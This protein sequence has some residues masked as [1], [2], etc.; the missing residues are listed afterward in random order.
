M[1]ISRYTGEALPMKDSPISVFRE[2]R[3]LRLGEPRRTARSGLDWIA[4]AI[5][6][7][8]IG[9]IAMLA[10]KVIPLERTYR[11]GRVY[12]SRLSIMLVMAPIMVLGAAVW[13]GYTRWR[14]R[15]TVPFAFPVTIQL[16]RWWVFR[17]DDEMLALTDGADVIC[18]FCRPAPEPLAQVL[19]LVDPGKELETA[20]P[21]GDSLL[22]DLPDTPRASG[23][24]MQ[25]AHTPGYAMVFAATEARVDDI[26]GV[27]R[28]S[29]PRDMDLRPQKWRPLSG[30]NIVRRRGAR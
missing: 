17:R 27:L 2:V 22:F 15:G 20:D 8:A 5:A 28:K 14:D 19:D 7:V 30:E 3:R 16:P 6:I 9:G 26:A 21:E 12:T 18:L 25:L 24:V 11:N 23:M 29:I 10:F 1:T 13:L 4:F